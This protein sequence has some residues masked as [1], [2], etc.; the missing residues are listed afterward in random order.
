MSA[1]LTDRG[2]SP[3]GAAL[4]V[5]A[6]GGAALIGRWITGWLLDRFFAPRVAAILLDEN[7][8]NI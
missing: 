2:L 3:A 6:V 4:A 7:S 1:L 8:L 5:S